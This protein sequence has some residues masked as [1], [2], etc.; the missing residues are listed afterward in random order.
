MRNALRQ[1]RCATPPGR[2][3]RALQR[4]QERR[5][6]RPVG[7]PL[8][9][10]ALQCQVGFATVGG[11]REQLFGVLASSLPQPDAPNRV[12]NQ[13]SDAAGQGLIVA[14]RVGQSRL[15]I[16]HEI[17]RAC[18]VRIDDGTAEQHGFH[19]DPA[20]ALGARADQYDV[21]GS[22]QRIRIGDMADTTDPIGD[23]EFIDQS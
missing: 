22:D 13:V 10:E 8:I 16:D 21:R 6:G 18:A 1:E 5:V 23:A 12:R 9:P 7:P 14:G 15:S 3:L 11:R 17:R 20:E 2:R 4:G 19:C